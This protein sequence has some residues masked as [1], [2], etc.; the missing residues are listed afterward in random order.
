MQI[1]TLGASSIKSNIP[2]LKSM[3]AT[4]CALS[5]SGYMT[6]TAPIR[7]NV[8]PWSSLAARDIMNGID[9]LLRSTVTN[10]LACMLSL[11]NATTATSKSDTSISLRTVSLVASA[12]TA[13]VT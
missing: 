1:P 2:E 7:S 6:L 5:I 13:Y 9:R 12:L 11:P 8:S 4:R 3:W 10:M